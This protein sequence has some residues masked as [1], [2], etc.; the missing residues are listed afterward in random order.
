VA[1]SYPFG[2]E[3]YTLTNTFKHSKMWPRTEPKLK[4]SSILN[5]G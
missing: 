1:E 2:I 3:I 4:H 5:C